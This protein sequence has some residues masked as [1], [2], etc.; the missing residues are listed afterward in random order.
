SLT[1][2]DITTIYEDNKNRLWVGTIGGGLSLLEKGSFR[3]FRHDPKNASSLGHNNIKS[4]SQSPDGNIWI[5]TENGGL[6]ILNTQTWQFTTHKH[7]EIETT[8]ISNNSVDALLRDR[9]G[10]MWAGVYSG[11]INLF[12]NNHANFFH[13][14]HS[15]SPT[16]LSN[17]FVLSF[18]ELDKNSIWIGT[19]GGGLNKLDRATGTFK[20]YTRSNSGI[21]G[22][23]ILALESDANGNIWM[24][25]WGDGLSILNPRTGIFRTMRQEPGNLN[26]LSGNNI[27]A[28]ERTTDNQMWIGTFGAGLDNYNPETNTFTSYPHDPNNNKSV[29]SNLISALRGDKNGNLWIGTFDSGLNYF[30]TKTKTFKRYKKGKTAKDLSDNAITSILEDSKGMIWITTFYGINRFDPKTGKFTVYNTDHGLAHNYT[31]AVLEDDKGM[32]W[33]STNAGISKFN[34]QNQTF[35]NFGIESGLQQGEFKAK[36]AL[37]SSTGAMFFGGINGFNQFSPATIVRRPYN[38]QVVLT[39]FQIFNKDVSI[40]KDDR[41]PSPLKTDIAE[42]SAIEVSYKQSFLTFEFAALDMLIPR[43]KSY[44]YMLEGFDPD[45]N[46]VGNK[47]MAMYTNLPPGTYTFRVKAQNTAGD[48]SPKMASIK[49]TIV[50]PFW[51]T[52]W[53]KIAAAI[54]MIVLVYAIYR[55]RITNILRQ[56]ELLEKL[57]NERT[58]TIQNQADELHSQSEHLQ[59]LNE[60]LQAQSEELI[61]QAEE[62][63]HQKEHEQAVRE[64]AENAN[65]AKSI[66]LATMSHEIRTPMNGVIGMASLL[67]ETELNDEQREYTDAIVSCGDS[68][69]SVINDIL[70]FSKIESGNM[71]IEEEDFELRLVIE[72]V[73]DLFAKEAAKKNID[74]LYQIDQYL[75]EKI[76]GD[77][78]RLKQ[79][80]M[81][82]TSNAIKFTASG[83]V[84]INVHQK[85][86]PDDNSLQIGFTV[87]DT[88][89]G[90]P[91]DK[92][93]TLFKAFSQVDSSTTRR[94]GGTGLGLAISERLVKLMGGDIYAEST[95]GKGSSFSF[96]IRAGISQQVADD[97]AEQYDMADL[98][99][100]HVL[101]VDDNDTNLIILKAQLEQWKLIPILA[102]SATQALEILSTDDAISLIITDMEMPGMDGVSLARLNKK[103]SKPHP[104]IMLSSIG[105]ETKKKYPGLF[106]AILT[107]PVK[108]RLLRKSIQESLRE[109]SSNQGI[110]KRQNILDEQFAVD[111]PLSILVAED[112]PI[113]QRLILQILKK[114]GYSAVMTNN[115]Y[116]VLDQ[117][118]KADYDLILMDVQM[119]EMDGLEATR[120]I[121]QQ[122][123]H[124]PYIIAMTGNAMSEDRNICL[125]EGMNDYLAKPM[126][127]ESIKTALKNAFLRA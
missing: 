122:T 11:G 48:W 5:G 82:L 25:T 27:Y 47:N 81:N 55:Y 127:L 26:G 110:S 74:L 7:D 83:E 67:R 112:N 45:W 54:L 118:K 50:P 56:K 63:F 94:Y 99:G 33:V 31:Q 109:G 28:I 114:L 98:A 79:V 23:Y 21:S 95:A 22:N 64:E 60:E 121:R 126:K 92:L 80:L 34:P 71:D 86:M 88:G 107:K 43:L 18:L 90:I 108:K 46:Y 58:Q 15:S 13:Y 59:S 2:D 38:T 72:E 9:D 119:P 93:N 120:R 84:F 24:G 91:G 87:R 89:I 115:G 4:I 97:N 49:I 52:W 14:T 104:V 68:L 35:T 41:D 73:M 29:S 16:S 106:S 65:K 96:H 61:A 19:D 113:N 123:V 32:L 102:S 103:S 124:Q 75:P 57:V 39:K 62:L 30:N 12:K 77:S 85:S 3:H 1:D 51:L 100:K 117:L 40:A 78:L 105:D 69:V 20:S 116:E 111:Y 36:S 53:F 42:A 101:I 10:N 76:V 70:D 6:S 125:R 8:S 17:N 37:K 66:F 44:A